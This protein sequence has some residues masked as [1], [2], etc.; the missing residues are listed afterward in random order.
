VAS[1][2]RNNDDDISDDGLGLEKENCGVV[3]NEA[4]Y[5][6]WKKIEYYEMVS[7]AHQRDEGL[8]WL[9]DLHCRGTGGVLEM[10]WALARPGRFV[11]R[12]HPHPSSACTLF[13]I[14]SLLLA[15]RHL[16]TLNA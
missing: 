10:T 13:L 2:F 16:M 14:L 11:S 9:W 12:A 5:V 7:A 8:R 6:G 1:T 15:Q 3:K 4:E